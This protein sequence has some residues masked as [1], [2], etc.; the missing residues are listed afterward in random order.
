MSDPFIGEIRLFAGTYAPV[1]WLPC[2]GRLLAVSEYQMLFALLGTLY[3][4]DGKQHFA[5][6]DLRDRL[7][8]GQGEGPGLT[9][10]TIGQTF[11]QA[12]VT[13]TS[14][15]MPAHQHTIQASNDIASTGTPGPGVTLACLDPNAGITL[16]DTG[17]VTP[18]MQKNFSPQA[19]THA[20]ESWPHNNQMPTLALN[21]II[22]INGIFPAQN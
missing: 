13:L 16:Y 2:D 14:A 6:P 12:E 10:R 3:G 20:G 21:Y 5:L 18:N 9:P 17:V 1:D 7:P 8:V 15:Q 4:G 22:A 11:G 19:C